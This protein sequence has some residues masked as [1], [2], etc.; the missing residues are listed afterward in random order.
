MP[1]HAKYDYKRETSG[2]ENPN[3]LLW[4]TST[5]AQ[6]LPWR[7]IFNLLDWIEKKLSLLSRGRTIFIFQDCLDYKYLWK[8]SSLN[9]FFKKDTVFLLT[10]SAEHG[11]L[12]ESYL[13]LWSTKRKAVLGQSNHFSSNIHHLRNLKKT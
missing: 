2:F 12:M 3:I 1:I 11:K 13:P 6:Y 4:T 8:D 7:E 9:I 5:P 10:G